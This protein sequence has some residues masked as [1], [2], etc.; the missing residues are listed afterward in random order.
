MEQTPG[1]RQ[2]DFRVDEIK[3]ANLMPMADMISVETVVNLL[4]RK[5]ICTPEEF[6]EEERKRQEYSL[7]FKNVGIIQTPESSQ[8]ETDYKVK[9]QSW[10]KRKM[11]KYRWSRKLGTALFG[12]KWKKVKLGH[13]S[14]L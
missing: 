7:K 8:S 12:W 10:L 3:S 9:K 11:S 2:H 14:K 13:A 6:F 5:G 1:F 4:I